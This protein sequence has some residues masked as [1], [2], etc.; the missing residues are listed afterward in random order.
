MAGD[1][2]AAPGTDLAELLLPFAERLTTIVPPVLTRL[3]R[4]VD[5]R[6]PHTQ[7]NSLAGSRKN[8]AG[9]LRPQQRPVRGLPRR[10]D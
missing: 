2:R 9:A 10:D 1:W 3:R 7:R 8:I 4:V 5:R 6:I